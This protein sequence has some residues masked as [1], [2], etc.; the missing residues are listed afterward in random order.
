MTAISHQFRVNIHTKPG[1]GGVE[2]TLYGVSE[3]P[4]VGGQVVK[5]VEGQAATSPVEVFVADLDGELTARLSKL[6][7]NVNRMDLIG[8][9]AEV[10]RSEDGG[11]Y[12]TVSVCRLADLATTQ[13]VSEYKLTLSD[14]RWMERRATLWEGLCDTCHVYPPGFHHDWG[15]YLPGS[16][17]GQ[18]ERV[19]TSGNFHRIRIRS[20]AGISTTILDYIKNDLKDEVD[21]GADHQRT[22][23]EG[24]FHHLRCHLD[25]VNYPIIS[26]DG[27]DRPENTFI[28]SLAQV[29]PASGTY[30][31]VWVYAPGSPSAVRGYIWAPTADP[32]ET[33]PLHIG[34]NQELVPGSYWGDHAWGYSAWGQN[35]FHLVE[36]IYQELGVRYESTSMQQLQDDLT[37]PRMKWRI[38]KPVEDVARWLEDNI[39]GPLHVVPFIDN[40]GRIK[41]TNVALPHANPDPLNQAGFFDLSSAFVFDDSNLASPPSWDHTSRDLT[42]V[43]TFSYPVFS[44][45]GL[46]GGMAGQQLASPAHPS[47]TDFP[48]DWLLLD[49]HTRSQDHDNT[50]ELGKFSIEFDMSGFPITP[51]MLALR[52]QQEDPEPFYTYW[53]ERIARQ[54]FERFGDGP[55]RG[56]MIS[57]RKKQD[58]QGRTPEG[59]QQGD[60]VLIS[61]ATYPNAEIRARGGYRLV[62]IMSRVDGPQ[63][64]HWE[65]LD[66]GPALQP[67]GTPTV[68]LAA[69]AGDPHHSVVVT[70]SNVPLNATATVHISIGDDPLVA[71]TMEGLT[72]GSYRLRQLPSGTE[73]RA[74]AQSHAPG[75]ISSPWSTQA[76]ITTQAL[77]P[78]TI[79]VADIT[80]LGWVATVPFT[81]AYDTYWI[82]PV[83]RRAG[84]GIFWNSTVWPIPPSSSF[85]PFILNQGS[86][87]F[88]VG[89]RTVDKYGGSSAPAF[90]EVITE[91]TPK[92]LLAPRRLQIIQGRTEETI[93]PSSE[94]IVGYGLEVSFHPTEIHAETRVRV[95]L[96]ED[97]ATIESEFTVGVGTDRVHI[98]TPGLDD[99]DRYVQMR[100]ERTGF[101]SSSWSAEVVVAKPTGLLPFPVPD[102][103]AGGAAWFDVREGHQLE[104]NV[105]HGADPDTD[106]VYWD[107]VVTD[108]EPA[109]GEDYPY[110]D[111]TEDEGGGD[112]GDPGYPD[113]E[114]YPPEHHPSQGKLLRTDLPYSE[115]VEQ[116]D[117]ALLY[118]IDPVTNDP[119]DP[120]L[121]Y[122]GDIVWGTFKFW[123]RD[124]GWG[125]VSLVKWR[126]PGSSLWAEIAAWN[127]QPVM[128]D[129]RELPEDDHDYLSQA[130]WD[131]LIQEG[132]DFEKSVA[133]YWLDLDM[134][135]GRGCHSLRFYVMSLGTNLHIKDQGVSG[136]L[137]AE[138]TS[139]AYSYLPGQVPSYQANKGTDEESNNLRYEY[140]GLITTDTGGAGELDVVLDDVGYGTPQF[141]ATK[142]TDEI[143]TG[144]VYTFRIFDLETTYWGDDVT[145]CGVFLSYWYRLP[146]GTWTMVREERYGPNVDIPEHEVTLIIPGMTQ[147]AQFGVHLRMV[148][149]EVAGNGGTWPVD[150]WIGSAE[151]AWT[152]DI[153]AGNVAVQFWYQQAGAWHY[154]SQ[155]T[156]GAGL[157]N[158]VI[159]ASK[160][161]PAGLVASDRFGMHLVETEPI[162]VSSFTAQPVT[163]TTQSQSDYLLYDPTKAWTPNEWV[164]YEV[165]IYAGTGAGQARVIE[166]NTTDTLR[167]KQAWSEP[168]DAT[169][170]YWILKTNVGEEGGED[171][172]VSFYDLNVTEDFVHRIRLLDGEIHEAEVDGALAAIGTSLPF[173]PV[174]Y[175]EEPDGQGGVVYSFANSYILTV[176]PYGHEDGG[177]FT[178]DI[179]EGDLRTLEALLPGESGSGQVVENWPEDDEW[180]WN[181]L[182]DHVPIFDRRYGQQTRVRPFF[183]AKYDLEEIQVEDDEGELVTVGSN[184]LF[185][186]GVKGQVDIGLA[187][188]NNAHL[189]KRWVEA[190]GNE[191]VIWESPEE[192]EDVDPDEFQQA[193]D[194]EVIV[195][196]LTWRPDYRKGP[197]QKITLAGDL[198]IRPP[199]NIRSGETLHIQID[200]GD[201][202][203]IWP[204]V[205]IQFPH[206]V[207]PRCTGTSWGNF[208]S[209]D[210]TNIVGL[211]LVDLGPPGLVE[212]GGGGGGGGGNGDGTVNPFEK[213][214]KDTLDSTQGGN[215]QEELRVEGTPDETAYITIT[216]ED[217]PNITEEMSQELPT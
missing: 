40:L 37:Y 203:V 71:R 109:P 193:V 98:Y 65:Y 202:D 16:P 75:R 90:T 26:F 13:R 59:V 67:L 102:S 135:I 70:L 200:S 122:P 111:V 199:K 212:L 118:L 73:I 80:V 28:N 138:L 11:A 176:V 54:V 210:G 209:S 86:T 4:A 14:E 20:A 182:L 154:H 42:N 6:Q 131:L 52:P 34:C 47:H 83:Q 121:V 116:R 24:N 125:Q 108:A 144:N 187:T 192:N 161:L 94:S 159:A 140:H 139:G 68:S 134:L 88:H 62:Q 22:D 55:I 157:T 133:R 147:G 204:Q 114:T 132:E 106:R 123:N 58:G 44:Q 171:E 27:A 101:N 149:C 61:S 177:Q 77:Q 17:W 19:K 33:V 197:L 120:Q 85:W 127:W 49:E 208:I 148:D 9:V 29:E 188:E 32:S 5:P 130:D 137:R 76:T 103:F 113:Y 95:G 64:I 185:V 214:I 153:Q 53:D 206:G 215:W 142:S 191:G 12:T 152:S 93:I 164:D 91:A 82:Q 79:T 119:P 100:H 168:P 57:L 169:S 162:T 172:E 196:M 183:Q 126:V 51:F 63:G 10:Q 146:G 170:Q 66:A 207:A 115:V 156:V 205:G 166:S 48:A 181:P 7:G 84:V 74:W 107:Y 178:G 194:D 216:L 87:P 165:R 184:P 35:V 217:D 25:G 8:R 41:L 72:N 179:L 129:R 50:D 180:W 43:V 158:H 155:L 46:T 136:N 105:D 195:E 117:E 211:V 31:H 97:F 186:L 99:Q 92:I 45:V 1:Y 36:K 174:G 30:F 173:D 163:W 175:Y 151:V 160:V 15:V 141:Q 213:P 201:F 69:Y 56:R 190:S 39:F 143:G 23:G 60:L 110:P 150:G 198:F 81:P 3:Y 78:P 189:E 128:I 112:P 2:F 89:F 104:V 18:A 145:S 167:V 38:T 21:G 96:S 124:K